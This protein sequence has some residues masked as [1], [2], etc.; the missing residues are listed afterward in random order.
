M[1]KLM[2]TLVLNWLI[3]GLNAQ[4]KDTPFEKDFFKD[5]KDEF[6]EA[7]KNFEEGK[8]LYDKGQARYEMAIPFLEKAYDFN[9]NYSVLN[10]ML[11]RCYMASLY[12]FKSLDKFLA[13]YELN[14]AVSKDIH[15]MIGHAYQLKYNWDKAVYHYELYRKTLNQKNDVTE[16]E[17][18]NKKIGECATGKKLQAKP[19]RVWVDNLGKNI[20]TEYPEYSPFISADE[21]VIVFTARRPD[22]QGGKKD[23]DPEIGDFKYFEDIYISYRDENGNWTK[24]KNMGGKINTDNF[25]ASAGLSPDGKQ[26]FVYYGWKGRGDIYSSKLINNEW[27]KP[28]KL[29][30]TING[31]STWETSATISWDGKELFFVS[32]RPG[33]YGGSDIWVC[34]WDEKKK[35]WNEPKNLGPTINTKYEERGVFFHPDGETMYFASNGQETMGGLDIFY[36]KRDENGNWSKPINMGYP[37]NSPDDD[38]FFVVSGNGRYGYYASFKEEGMGEKDLYRITFL[39]PEKTPM[40]NTE[41]NLIASLANPVREVVIEP[42]VEVKSSNLAILKGLIR[43]LKTLQPLEASIELIDNDKNELVASF[44]SDAVTGQYMVSIPAGK[45]YG[46]FVKKDG[47]LSHSENIDLPKASG[48]KEYEKNID[49]KPIEVGSSIVLRN[50]FFDLDKATL[51]PASTAELERLLKLLNENPTLRIEIS[52]HTDS[53]GDNAYNQKL[54]EARAKAVVDYLIKNNIKATRLEY[55]GYGEEKPIIPEADIMKMKT[56]TEREEAHQQNRRTE[57]KILSK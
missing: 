48:Y 46:I 19:E 32:D 9:P 14:N 2:I 38:V 13:A 4:K 51:R 29:D 49:M 7:K 52:G 10:Y 26:M 37:I 18:V 16:I 8:K 57:F 27:T 28:E 47:F 36:T 53:Q 1:R 30:K 54:S 41:D 44:S 17:L 25:D 55:K 50:I 40:L 39:G 34:T 22:T 15:L 45:N 5:R 11:G 31:E 21:S 12:K 33:G 43:N 23:E 6:K 42:K 35:K 20:N 24:A 3:I 56:K